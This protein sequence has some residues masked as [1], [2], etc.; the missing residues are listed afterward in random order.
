MYS[1]ISINGI[2]LGHVPKEVFRRALEDTLSLIMSTDM[3]TFDSMQKVHEGALARRRL[4]HLINFID[5]G[6]EG[7][8]PEEPNTFLEVDRRKKITISDVDLPSQYVETI[9]VAWG[10][11]EGLANF[12]KD[13]KPILDNFR[14]YLGDGTQNVEYR[15]MQQ[16]DLSR[17]HMDPPPNDGWKR[18]VT[19]G[20]PTGRM[21]R[22][23]EENTA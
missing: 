20:V 4:L 3:S 13:D 16:S 2:M 7:P 18:E 19:K 5:T 21:F 10:I 17:I 14:L 6:A 1:T 15:A 11:Y 12:P 8:S 23:L 22:R 9:K